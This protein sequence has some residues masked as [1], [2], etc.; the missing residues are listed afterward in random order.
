M[1]E[2]KEI[3]GTGGRYFVSN[4]GR[5]KSV[6][7][8][9]KEIYLK[10]HMGTGGYLTLNIYYN[11]KPTTSAIH[12]LV[13]RAFLGET[14][15]GMYVNHKDGNKLNNKLTNLEYVTPKEN[16]HHAF[17]TGL[18]K[19]GEN[20]P[21]SKLKN[22]DVI[23]IKLYQKL[24]YTEADLAEKFNVHPRT[25]RRIFNREPNYR[26]WDGEDILHPIVPKTLGDVGMKNAINEVEEDCPEG[27]V[28]IV[29]FH[30]R[31]KNKDGKRIQEAGDYVALSLEDFLN[32]VDKD[33]II[34]LKEKKPKKLK[35]L[36]GENKS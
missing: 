3:E 12:R 30:R 10:P 13:A 25:I 7:N 16:S 15:K 9:G 21:N 33:K 8:N 28:P 32:I 2:W 24:G 23:L 1:E 26:R 31:Q 6:K 36:K 34:V 27:K 20:H 4:L 14:E 35:N 19:S 22:K 18:N 5:V 17:S 11:S 29:V